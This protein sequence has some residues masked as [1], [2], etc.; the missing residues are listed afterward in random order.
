MRRI[1][2]TCVISIIAL[3]IG[4]A[5]SLCNADV[6]ENSI[7]ILPFTVTPATAG[8]SDLGTSTLPFGKGEFGSATAN[9]EVGQ[10][11]GAGYI[12]T[13]TAQS[14]ILMSNGTF[15]WG[16]DTSGNFAQSAGAA[17]IIFS[18]T[19]K[20]IRIDSGTPASACAGTGTHNGTTAVTVSTTC[21]ATGARVFFNDTSEPTTSSGCWVTN[22]VN[23]TSFDVDCKS[24]GQD[25]TFAWWIQ[26]EG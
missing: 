10:G 25:A 13:N 5:I 15:R 18:L 12:G 8:G 14:M 11:A 26:K 4:L 7:R 1:L 21:A 3:P 6:Y 16:V 19:G 9:V 2:R 23:G 22:I 20:T 17:D 24:A